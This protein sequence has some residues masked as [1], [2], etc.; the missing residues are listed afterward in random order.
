MKLWKILLIGIS[1]AILPFALVGVGQAQQMTCWDI[2]AGQT[3]NERSAFS[4][5]HSCQDNADENERERGNSAFCRIENEEDT[6]DED[7]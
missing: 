6:T 7:G 4:A 1:V 2:L 5:R 3:K